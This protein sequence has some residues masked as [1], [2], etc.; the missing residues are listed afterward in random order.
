MGGRMYMH[1]ARSSIFLSNCLAKEPARKRPLAKML[2]LK[3]IAKARDAKRK[4]LVRDAATKQPR[5]S[6]RIRLHWVGCASVIAVRVV[7]TQR[8][9]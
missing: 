5:A 9:S 6:T 3:R 8:S 2:K 7:K 4:E 1:L